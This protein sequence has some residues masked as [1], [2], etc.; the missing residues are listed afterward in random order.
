MVKP[1]L[2]SKSLGDERCPDAIDIEDYL[3]DRN[4]SDIHVGPQGNALCK[5]NKSGEQQSL[6]EE[7]GSAASDANNH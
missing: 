1:P 2:K 7:N 6:P 3:N 4:N 5:S